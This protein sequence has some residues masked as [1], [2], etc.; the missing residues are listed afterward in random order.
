M[1]DN[2]SEADIALVREAYDLWASG[3]IDDF[4]QFIDPGIA[5]A[6]RAD[7][8][9]VPFGGSLS[10]EAAFRVHLNGLREIFSYLY[11]TPSRFKWVDGVVH[12]RV[13]FS[14]RHKSSGQI[15]TGFVGQAVTVR[16]GRITSIE[17][18][19]DVKL[20]EAF[21]AMTSSGGATSDTGPRSSADNVSS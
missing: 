14:L 7:P 10:G 4:M 21:F 19:P 3:S 6:L 17:E 13:D 11:Y 8:A 15:L 18:F 16:A 2:Q 1:S 9:V 12:F 5:Y 20:L